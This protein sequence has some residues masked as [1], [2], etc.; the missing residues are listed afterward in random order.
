MAAV[1]LLL[2]L[3]A[4]ALGGLSLFEHMPW[5]EV[6]APARAAFPESGASGLR[7]FKTATIIENVRNASSA[8]DWTA[9]EDWKLSSLESNPGVMRSGVS[10]EVHPGPK[11]G[12]PS[13]WSSYLF[14]EAAEKNK[15][16]LKPEWNKEPYEFRTVEFP[17]FFED[18]RKGVLHYLGGFEHPEL[19][20]D[21]QVSVTPLMSVTDDATFSHL[22][23]TRR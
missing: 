7:A 9:F 19:D 14:R 2:S 16:G 5:L 20:G 23:V 11:F 1:L 8:R 3:V 22:R 10:S 15:L 12:P 17:Q 4:P 18:C 21:A 6:V 13:T